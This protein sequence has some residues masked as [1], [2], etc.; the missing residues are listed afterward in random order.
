MTQIA[1]KSYNPCEVLWDEGDVQEWEGYFQHI[2]RSS[3]LQSRIYG[4]VMARLNQQRAV[5]GVIM[6]NQE[7]AGVVQVLEAGLFKNAVQGVIVDRGPLWLEGFGSD[8]DF[9]S[10]LQ[11]FREIYPKR[12][13][14]RVR[15]IP[16]RPNTPQI[17]AQMKTAQFVQKGSKGYQ[18]IWLDLRCDVEVLNKNLEKK[19]RASLRKAQA[20]SDLRVVWDFKGAYLDYFLTQYAADKSGK[21]YNG[22]SVKTLRALAQGFGREEKSVIGVALV[23]NQPVACILVFVHGMAATYQAGYTSAK[24]REFCAH[25]RLLW[26]AL[27]VLK[28][29]SVYDFD[30]G[31]VNTEG[32]QGIFAFKQG[33]GGQVFETAGLYV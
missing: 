10:F 31:G 7:T 17:T 12:F 18:T 19:W 32:A 21:A 25:H 15:F 11:H 1:E 24:G 14:R 29:R 27:A 3:L 5:C 20:Q 33:M 26:D 9:A 8:A 28:E 16:E 6:I 30:L 4:D 13:G 22:A 2:P 23:D